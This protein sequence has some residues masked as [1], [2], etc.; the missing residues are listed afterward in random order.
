MFICNQCKKSSLPGEFCNKVPSG[1][2]EVTYNLIMLKR[3]RSSKRLI[4]ENCSKDSQKVKDLIEKE[5][6]EFA[7]GWT[8]RG[9]E[10][11]KELQLCKN[12]YKSLLVENENKN[13]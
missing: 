4:L 9:W 2:K 3:K 13:L 5:N 11:K 1:K 7:R 8:S 6:W 10:M 12:C